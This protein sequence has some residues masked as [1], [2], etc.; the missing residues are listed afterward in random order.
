ME[1]SCLVVEFGRDTGVA[2]D[3]IKAVKCNIAHHNFKAF[4][5]RPHVHYVGRCAEQLAHFANSLSRKAEIGSHG[6]ILTVKV[7]L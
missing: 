7:K 1:F 5:M 4:T 2:F 6:L 3:E